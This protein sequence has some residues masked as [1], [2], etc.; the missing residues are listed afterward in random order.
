[1]VG[2]EKTLNV[3]ASL[4]SLDEVTAFFEDTLADEGCPHKM[5]MQVIVCVEEIFVNVA[6]YAYNDG[7]GGSC[8]LSITVDVNDD[9]KRATI[10]VADSGKPFNPLER[11]NPDIT[12]TA[13]EREIGGLGIFMVKKSMDTLEYEYKSGENILMMTKNWKVNCGDKKNNADAQ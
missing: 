4:D 5:I 8:R 7:Q 11:E 2:Q 6:S 3:D 12:L 1:M 10:V 9:K 13:D